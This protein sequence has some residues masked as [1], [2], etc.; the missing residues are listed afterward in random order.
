MGAIMLAYGVLAALLARERHGVGQ[1]VDT[2][3]YGTMLWLRG[4]ALALQ[5]MTQ[6]SRVATSQFA[7]HIR[8]KPSSRENPGNPLWNTYRCADGKWIALAMV[9]SDPHWPTLLQALGNP[10]PL[11]SDPRFADH[12]SRCENAPDCV[13]LLDEVFATLPREEWLRRV[14][15][16]G[17]LLPEELWIQQ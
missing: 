8:G 17:D 13:A 1:R 3:L 16:K 10:E 9:Q 4:L 2:S 6:D 14:R 15:A 12:L 7:K 11:A 5:L